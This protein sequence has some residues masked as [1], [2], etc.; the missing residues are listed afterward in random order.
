[1]NYWVIKSEPAAYSWETFVKEKVS[2]WDGVRN[3]QARNNMMKMKIG[4]LLLFYHSN[5]A[6]E[7]VGLAE[8]V[9]ESYPD[10]T[11]DDPR[12]VMVDVK[13]LKPFKKPVPLAL[14][15]EIPELAN[16]KLVRQSRLSVGEIDKKSFE[17]ILKLGGMV[18]Y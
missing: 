6:R 9:K 10:H 12:W 3:Y 14:I 11:A 5:G 1:M 17:L 16:I 2:S 7:V 8:V 4:D 15:K 13:A 18:L